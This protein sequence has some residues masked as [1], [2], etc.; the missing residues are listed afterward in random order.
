MST[1]FLR[2]GYPEDIWTGANMVLRAM[3][4]DVSSW[5]IVL[6]LRL[7]N[8]IKKSLEAQSCQQSCSSPPHGQCDDTILPQHW[9]AQLRLEIGCI[10]L[11]WLFPSFLPYLLWLR[12]KSGLT[13]SFYHANKN[14]CL[15]FLLYFSPRS[16]HKSGFCITT[17]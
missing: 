3:K 8:T 6:M 11:N 5:E 15:H 13:G 10:I 14:N 12:V 7:W 4:K 16:L 9:C 2:L 1:R 17:I